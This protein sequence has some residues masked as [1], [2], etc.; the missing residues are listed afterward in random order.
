MTQSLIIKKLIP[1]FL[2]LLLVSSCVVAKKYKQP[3]LDLPE[4]YRMELQLTAD[5]IQLP[6]RT[7]FKDK[8]LITLIGNALQK[9]NEI[10]VALKSVEQLDLAFKQA[11]LEWLPTLELSGSV[12]RTWQS[13]NSMNGSL[14]GQFVST[15][16]IDDYMSGL[17]LNWEM[18]I[19]GKT[20]MMKAATRADYFA[21]RENVAALKT[22]IIVQVAQ[23]Y[24]NLLALDEQLKIATSNIELSDRTLQIMQL[25]Y[26]AGQ[27][28]S[29]AVQ[30]A[31]A[32]KKTAEMV[33]P[34]AMQQIAVQENA[35]SILCG[36]YPDSV[37]RA[38][39]LQKALPED[40]ATTGIPA[41]LLSRRPDVK[42]AEYAVI[43]A[44]AKAGLANAAMYP[45]LSL[46]PQ[47]GTN[48]M[49]FKDWFDLPGSVTKN[50]AA[51]LTQPL[52]QKKM[53]RTAYKIALI[54]HEKAAI[55]FKQTVLQAVGEVSDA[56]ARSKGASQRLVLAEEKGMALNKA[57]NDAMKLY[58]N[59]MANYLEVIT[60]QN[61]ALQN[62]LETI[63]I[64]LEKYNAITDLYR[65]LGGGVE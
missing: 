39:S 47:I 45:S 63:A 32:Q 50:I 6:W 34:L 62:E 60:A 9:N 42:A 40:L 51:N 59:G 23:A 20:S 21:Q 48:S 16:Y 3:A 15:P 31:E 12:N 22:R 38:E 17:R 64:H 30:Q 43:V 19:W 28:N 18:D 10:A 65:A 56:M 49:Q 5:T 1:G 27:I 35:L 33:L 24:Y 46:V 2:L 26:D 53:L 61:N 55:Q 8:Q 4:K 44:N 13:K 14:M 25:Q 11:K 52:F 36:A 41:A 57:T 37:A 54:E 29:L 58:A 7:F